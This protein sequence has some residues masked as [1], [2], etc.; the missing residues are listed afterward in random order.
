M[1]FASFNTNRNKL[2]AGLGTAAAGLL[3]VV[4]LLALLL[5][6]SGHDPGL[7]L[8]AFWMGSFGTGDAFASATLVRAVPLILAG[9]AIALAFRAGVWNIGAE[10]Q[11]LAGAAAASAVALGW[12]AGERVGAVGVILGL[13]AGALAGAS[14]A[15]IAGILR[16]RFGVLEIISTIML[17]FVALHVVGYLVRGPLQEPT[18]VYPQSATIPSAFRLPVLIPGT[19]LHSGVLIAVLCAGTGWV[20]L[21]HAAVGFRIRAAG[22]N[23]TTA[24]SAGMIDVVGTTLRVFIAS[25]ALAGLAGAVE[26]YGVT[27]AL[28]E[29]LSP[30]YG[31]SAIAVALLARLNPLGVLL[32]GTLLGALQVGGAAMQR[33]AGVPSVLVSIVEA[34]LILAMVAGA[35]RSGLADRFRRRVIS[36]PEEYPSARAT[37]T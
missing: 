31:Y 20:I 3:A 9:L 32:T 21:R 2:I 36:P 13:L 6:A 30:G 37:A 7:A 35:G 11:L 5:L 15:A 17:N 19:R 33:D 26:V 22:A 8:H 29:S 23:P 18:G 14:L 25:G 34:V 1:R 28:Y 12:S 4:S 16:A 27:Y 10:G 24:R